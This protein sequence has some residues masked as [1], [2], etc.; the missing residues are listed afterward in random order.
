MYLPRLRRISDVLK[1]MKS[2]D[3]QTV[4]SRHFIEAL[5]HTNEITALKYGC[6]WLINLDELYL[7]LSSQKE[8]YEDLNTEAENSSRRMWT[9]GEIYR[10]FLMEDSGT[11]VRKPN[12]RRF[13]KANNIKY[14]ITE[15]GKWLID[16]KE[17]IKTVN[18]KNLKCHI[19]MPRLRWHNDTVRKFQKQHPDVKITMNEIEEILRSNKVFTVLNGHRWIINYDELEQEIYKRKHKFI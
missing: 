2:A 4:I 15:T 14:G 5:V 19:D 3:E 7:Y 16:H 10:L 8:E 9:S 1:E 18:P 12:M 13:V 17:F 6:A 11:I